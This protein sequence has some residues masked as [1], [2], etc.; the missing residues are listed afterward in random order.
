MAARKV[1]SVVAIILLVA[2]ALLIVWSVA[3][4]IGGFD[5]PQVVLDS[6]ES[7]PGGL[8]WSTPFANLSDS[9][10][11]YH[12]ST[13]SDTYYV[14]GERRADQPDQPITQIDSIGTTGGGHAFYSRDLEF[15]SVVNAVNP[16]DQ[17]RGPMLF[18]IHF[19]N[20][21][22]GQTATFSAYAS[23]E[24]S[25]ASLVYAAKAYASLAGLV[26]G[27]AGVVLYIVRAGMHD[28][29]ATTEASPPPPNP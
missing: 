21:P 4:A 27:V 17:S 3:P 18:W 14:L 16:Q 19:P 11:T 15:S 22:S 5:A 1:L 28:R 25:D 8:G 7:G 12:L 26:V 23:Y 13:S 2:G 29:P 9:P 24:Y 10:G 6:K 20:L